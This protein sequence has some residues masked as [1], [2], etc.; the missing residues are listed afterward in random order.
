MKLRIERHGTGEASEL[1]VTGIDG[2][3][4][5]VSQHEKTRQSSKRR[6][7]KRRRRAGVPKFISSACRNEQ[8]K[9]CFTR[10]K[11]GCVC[12]ESRKKRAA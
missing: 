8:H 9:A 1:T 11:C 6:E 2:A 4:A 5:N 7:E 3:I 10:I 12:H